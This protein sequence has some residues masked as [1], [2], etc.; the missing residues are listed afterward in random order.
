MLP[1]EKGFVDGSRCIVLPNSINES[2]FRK[3]NKVE[4]R[5]KLNISRDSFVIAFCGRF[6]N[7]KGAFRLEQAL[8]MID[9]PDIKSVFIGMPETGQSRKPSCKGIHF[10]G[11][12]PHEKVALY[13][14]AAD[15]FVLPS[16]AEGCSNSIVEALACGLP[17]ISS[18][19]SFNYDILDNSNAILIDPNN[20]EAIKNAILKLRDND[21]LREGMA[22]NSLC[23]VKDLTIEKRVSRIV[24]FIKNQINEKD[25]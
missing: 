1:I 8:N 6:N 20:V 17:I 19:L 10:C 7:R 3:I 21:E 13:L 12:L 22:V 23:K 16:L 15:V 5:N 24:N 25:N 4:A 2:I 18:D 9:D 14:N 11:S